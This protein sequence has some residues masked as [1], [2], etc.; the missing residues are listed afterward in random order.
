MLVDPSDKLSVVLFP[1]ATFACACISVLET[2]MSFAFTVIPYP[3]IAL[4]VMSPDVPPPVIPAPATT[5]VT[6]PVRSLSI[7]KVPAAS[8]YVTV[9]LAPPDTNTF[10]LS[11]TASLKS[12]T[13]SDVI[14]I[15]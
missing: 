15:A 12:V 9:I 8:S 2:S 5:P 7:T 13:W 14:A 4:T 1:I 10:T 6:S 11:S 3:P